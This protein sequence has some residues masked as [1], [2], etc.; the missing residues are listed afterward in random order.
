VKTLHKVGQRNKPFVQNLSFGLAHLTGLPFVDIPFGPA[1]SILDLG[2]ILVL[3]T[4]VHKE[5]FTSGRLCGASITSHRAFRLNSQSNANI[6]EGVSMRCS[7]KEHTTISKAT[8]FPCS[9]PV[10]GCKESE[11]PVVMSTTCCGIDPSAI[12]ENERVEQGYV[13]RSLYATDVNL[14][15]EPEFVSCREQLTGSAA[16][17]LG[18]GKLSSSRMGCTMAFLRGIEPS[19]G[20]C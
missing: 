20:V 12:S 6:S 14:C 9:S 8:M 5:M 13:V 1:P 2:R 10:V 16:A 4:S 18:L 7:A 15:C 11:V 19:S 17:I 3:P